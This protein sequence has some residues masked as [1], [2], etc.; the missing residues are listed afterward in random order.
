M[1]QKTI[2][3]FIPYHRHTMAASNI[4][5][6]WTRC[7]FL[8]KSNTRLKRHGPSRKARKNLKMPLTAEKRLIGSR[9]SSGS[10]TTMTCDRN[11]VILS[12]PRTN[13][14]LDAMIVG[15]RIEKLPSS[16]NWESHQGPVMAAGR[17]GTLKC[18]CARPSLGI[19][20][21]DGEHQNLTIETSLRQE[22]QTLTTFHPVAASTQNE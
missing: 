12:S 4:A 21:C 2:R 20:G 14:S 13:I 8:D 7:F 15:C 3:K 16:S 1:Q 9:D 5:Q 22:P 10:K 17:H 19:A 11:V 18:H 6:V